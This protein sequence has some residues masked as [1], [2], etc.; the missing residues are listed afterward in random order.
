MVKIELSPQTCGL[1]ILTGNQGLNA[2]TKR[3]TQ[4]EMLF[5]TVT[6]KQLQDEVKLEPKV[7]KMLY[8]D[9]KSHQNYVKKF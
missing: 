3:K 4:T 8:Y 6:M 7:E 2:I 1:T 5:I 9:H